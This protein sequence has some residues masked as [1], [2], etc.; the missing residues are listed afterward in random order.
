MATHQDRLLSAI[1]QLSYTLLTGAVG[2]AEN[3]ALSLDAMPDYLATAMFA[4]WCKL[5]NGAFKA[6]KDMSIA[7]R[8]DFERQIVFVT[9]YFALCH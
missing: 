9:T 8:D 7:Y 4:N 1:F 5:V 6:V 3:A 2:A